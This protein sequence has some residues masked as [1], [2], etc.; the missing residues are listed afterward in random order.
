MTFIREP[1]LRAQQPNDIHTT[2]LLGVATSTCFVVLL[3]LV[4]IKMAMVRS[5]SVVTPDNVPQR[6]SIL[7]AIT[8][9]GGRGDDGLLLVVAFDTHVVQNDPRFIVV[10]GGGQLP[11][12]LQHAGI[13]GSGCSR[14]C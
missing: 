14:D 12:I 8:Y 5:L 4:G 9:A 10:D 2:R 1:G 11:A 3:C 7:R 6:P 13:H